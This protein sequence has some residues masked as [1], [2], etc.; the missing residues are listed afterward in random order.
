MGNAEPHPLKPAY[1][2]QATHPQ[3]HDHAIQ[4]NLPPPLHRLTANVPAYTPMDPRGAALA[5]H[6]HQGLVGAPHHHQ[7]PPGPH[8]IPTSTINRQPPI[9]YGPQPRPD[10]HA[11]ASHP[12]LGTATSQGPQGPH[13]AHTQHPHD[14]EGHPE[15]QP[16]QHP[17]PPPPTP[18]SATPPPPPRP[19]H[20][21][22]TRRPRP[23]D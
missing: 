15:P 16:A 13:S 2:T 14:P 18:S 5:H 17:S 21:R 23:A 20:R 9:T 4:H 7:Q 19:G 12:H 1:H 3:H 8:P 6:Q 11:A 22:K 10:A